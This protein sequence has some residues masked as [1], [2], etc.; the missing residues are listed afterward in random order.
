MSRRVGIADLKNHLSE[1]LRRVEDGT[2]VVVFDRSRPVAR[3]VR[4]E[5]N[6]LPFEIRRAVRSIGPEDRK[7]GA[8]RARWPI[9][10]L[11]LLREER[12]RR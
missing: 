5:P 10:S 7:R 8:S 1:H 12:Q 4:V 11:E 2:E 9:D 3:I 6:R